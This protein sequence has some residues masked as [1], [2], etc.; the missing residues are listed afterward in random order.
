MQTNAIANTLSGIYRLLAI[1]FTFFIL[2]FAQTI[3]IPLTIAALL[4][5]LLSPFATALEK[6]VGRLPS[7]LLTVLTAFSVLGLA[8]YVFARQLVEFS[9]LFPTYYQLIQAKWQAFRI[10]GEGYAD[11]FGHLLD[12]FKSFIGEST[13]TDLAP[14]AAETQVKLIDLSSHITGFIESLLGSL[15]S[16][17]SMA[18]IVLLLVVFMLLNRDDIRARIIKVMGEGRISSTTGAMKDA[19]ERV[20]TYLLRLFVVNSGFGLSVFLGLSLIGIPNPILWGALAAVLRFIPYI[21]SWVAALIPIILSFIISDNWLTPILTIAFFA[22]LE[23]AT[24]YAVEPFYY[25][26]GTGVSSFA[27]ILA[28]I[29]WTW[30][31]GPIGLLL[32]TPLTVCLVVLGQH[33]AK[34]NFLRVMLSQEQPL[35]PAEECYHRLLLKDSSEAIENVESFLQKNSPIALYE[36]VFLPVISNTEKDF[37]LDLIDAEK[38]AEVYQSLA[39]MIELVGI[40]E[41]KRASPQTETKKQILCI[42]TRTLRDE[43]G[44]QILAQHLSSEGLAAEALKKESLY[45]INEYIEKIKSTDLFVVAVAPFILSHVRI[46]V[47]KVHQRH[48][49]LPL[50]LCLWGSSELDPFSVEKMESVGVTRIIYTLPQ[51]LKI[52]E[53]T[54]PVLEEQKS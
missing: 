8:G 26:G 17:F 18:G 7:I 9:S 36:E 10:T 6:W 11:Q 44:A 54:K 51:A 53:E 13:S 3:V 27:L 52:F 4:A 2:Y 16:I 5:F 48:P 49:E 31:W 28:A 50:T 39:E 22:V 34:M 14:Q 35:S 23:L 32:S 12:S 46:L 42:P 45:E 29:F 33:V 19:S 37:R 15:F 41:Q 21:G 1:A 20:T 24:A 30:L 38:K 40:S 47:A 25:G 43:L